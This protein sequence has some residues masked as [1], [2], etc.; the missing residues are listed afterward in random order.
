MTIQI[1][2]DKNLSVHETFRAQ[3]DNLLTEELERFSE[4]IT[5]LEI[6]LSDENGSK[7]GQDDKR[8]LL[9]ARL[10]GKQP[11]AVTDL[12]DTYENAVDGAIKKLK[13]SLDKIVG[14]SRNHN[15]QGD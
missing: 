2:T 14:R 1:N 7:K 8:C 15:N 12:A 4:H 13:S 9:E 6:H 10:E 3:L 11:I 5:R